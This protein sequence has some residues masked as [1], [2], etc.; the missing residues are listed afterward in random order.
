VGDLPAIT[1]PRPRQGRH[2]AARTESFVVAGARAIKGAQPAWL[3]L[4]MLWIAGVDVRVTLLALPPVLQFI[5]RD[6]RLTETA[7]A[8]LTGLPLV[9]LAAAAVPGSLLT[10]RFGARRTMIAGIVLL[11]VASGL[12]GA[13]TSIAVLFGMTFMMS[14]G[15]LTLPLVLP[16]A[17]GR[18]GVSLALCARVLSLVAP[19]PEPAR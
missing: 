2:A 19:E 12:R 4:V 5:H 8:V 7:T 1:G 14:V 11:A 15:M 18:W 3:G 16:L 10:A 6:L 13:W 17:A 9:L